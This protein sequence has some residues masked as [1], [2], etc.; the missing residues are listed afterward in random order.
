M[1][2]MSDSTLEIEIGDLSSPDEARRNAAT[3]RLIAI[4]LPATQPLIAALSTPGVLEC[5]AIV[6]TLVGIGEPAIKPLQAAMQ[7]ENRLIAQGA[8]Q[9]LAQIE[10]VM[11]MRRQLRDQIAEIARRKRKWRVRVALQFGI[12]LPITACLYWMR[13]NKD[14]PY[15]MGWII[16]GIIVEAFTSIGGNLRSNAIAALAYA[17]D[18]SMVGAI[19]TC[20]FDRDKWVRL[21]A[22]KALKNLL[23]SVKASDKRHIQPEEM[24]AL[25]KALDGRDDALRVAILKA[26]AQIGDAKAIPHVERIIAGPVTP[27]VRRVAEECLPYLRLRA[28][29]EQQA[30]TLLRA[31]TAVE[32][33]MPETLLRPAQGAV[34]SDTSQLLRPL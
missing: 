25:L 23:P 9:A 10:M 12:V 14:V 2:L 3:E 20:L 30:Q 31:S 22:A 32:V 1:M 6:R 4:G 8:K 34:S 15:W 16:L 26:L 17:S 28:E 18:V 33:A 11:Q 27:P 29:Q 21:D 24:N 5:Q 7:S 13:I 19:A